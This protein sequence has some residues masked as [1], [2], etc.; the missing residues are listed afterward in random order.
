MFGLYFWFSKKNWRVEVVV[1]YTKLVKI[2]NF[3]FTFEL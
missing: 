1:S 3:L 2:V